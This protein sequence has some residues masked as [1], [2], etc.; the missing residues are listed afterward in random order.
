MQEKYSKWNALKQELN[1]EK[2]IPYFR[3]WQAWFINMWLNIW[4]EQNWKKDDFKRPVLI[5]KKFNKDM[6]IWIALTK[7]IKKW[8]FYYELD[9]VKEFKSYAIL[10]QI[11]MY[12]SN[13]LISHIWWVDL[14]TLKDIKK[15]INKIIE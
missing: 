4:F 11:K 9:I 12:S 15:K 1:K 8:K 7:T 14:I 2:E 5:V 13:R 10:S 3:E 6:F